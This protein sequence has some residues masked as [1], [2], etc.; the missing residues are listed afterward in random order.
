MEQGDCNVCIGGDG[1]GEYC[2]VSDSKMVKARKPH[3][4]FECSKKIQPGETYERISQLYEGEWNRM[5]V[6]L[7]CSEISIAL[8]CDGR[9]LGNMWEEIRDY[10]FPNMTTGCLAKLKTVAAKQYLVEKWKEW[11]F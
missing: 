7:I 11:K 10:V 9:I 3:E 6:C 5:S 1:D 4:C 2:T 8:S